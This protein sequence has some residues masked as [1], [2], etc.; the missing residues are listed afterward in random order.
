[1]SMIAEAMECLQISAFLDTTKTSRYETLFKSIPGIQSLFEE[2]V[3][4]KDRIIQMLET[5]DREWCTFFED[6]DAFVQ[7]GC[8][9]VNRFLLDSVHQ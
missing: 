8:A 1:M 2:P 5:L 7:Q 6:F 4:N 3:K 9:K